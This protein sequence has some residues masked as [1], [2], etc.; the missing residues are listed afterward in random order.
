MIVLSLLLAAA[1]LEAPQEPL[2][3]G[4]VAVDSPDSGDLHFVRGARH[5]A[6]KQADGKVELLIERATT[7]QEI[8]AAVE[9][10]RAAG[11]A[12]IVAP[13]WLADAVRTKAAA[14]KLPCVTFAAP[15]AAFVQVL[16]HLIDRTLRMTRV[17]FV[18]DQSKGAKELGKLL[19]RDLKAPAVLVHEL[20]VAI[21]AKALGKEK[22]W[23]EGR[24]E[25][26]V[27]DADPA[28][29]VQFLE[30]TLG[31][32]P[33]TIVLTLRTAGD[34]VRAVSRRLFVV[35]GQST[36]TV[37]MTS[38]FRADYEKE[39]GAPLLGAAE[40]FEGVGAL[41]RAC[42]TAGSGDLA[43]INK[44]LAA[45][46]LEGTRG[47]YGFD[48]AAVAFTPPLA[49]WALVQKQW[50]PYVPAVVPLLAVGA[51]AGTD[52]SAGKPQ[53]TIG[54]PFGTWRTRQFVP[55][56]A[57]QWVL[58]SWADDGAYATIEDD[59]K[60]LGLSTGGADPVADH[61]VREEIMAR[62]MAIASTKFGRREDGTGVEGK[63]L[64]IAFAMH[65]PAKEREKRRLRI[66]PARFGGDHE[67]AGGEAF[68]TFCRVYSTFIRRTIFQPHALVPPMASDDC[69]YV[70]GSYR[71]GSDPAK[72]KRSEL[73][74]A[75]I[76]SYAG[77]MALTLAHEVGHLAGLGHVTDDPVEIMNVNEGAGIDYRDAHF[78]AA[79]WATMQQRY[80]LTGD[81][82]AKGAKGDKG[83]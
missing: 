66:W 7:P 51:S 70:D 82:P 36:A 77:S 32:E 11:V 49:V 22:E 33:V 64:R 52:V 56:D 76:N 26:I 12:G 10:L 34:A 50:K 18:R 59:L 42:R 3:I 80:G 14:A 4:V 38:A 29:A 48:A 23:I 35:H 46:V 9:K 1:V 57:A 27:I 65:V 53:T 19:A 67:G 47:R 31:P 63:S 15:H 44:A 79:S 17:A 69:E 39:H 73:I 30:K 16:D 25:L 37:A 74:R 54:E 28:A 41:V 6:A 13:P 5:A 62:T 78:G 61:L 2:R 8:T 71:F 45:T 40:G 55:E 81:K 24:P 68:G 75:L 58:C 21:T 20:D 43:A 72:D 60:Q 83:R